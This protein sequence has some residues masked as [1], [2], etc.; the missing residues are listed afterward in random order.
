MEKKIISTKLLYHDDRY[1]NNSYHN[2]VDGIP[3][4]ALLVTFNGGQI[5]GG[6]S[7]AAYQKSNINCDFKKGLMLEF[8]NGKVFHTKQKREN[9]KGNKTIS[10]PV[11]Y[12]EFYIIWGNSDLRIKPPT[13]QARDID[14]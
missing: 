1:N 4:I 12:D 7:E 11:S 8:T 10:R 9:S 5:I 2:Y 6:F 14:L 13:P 3:N